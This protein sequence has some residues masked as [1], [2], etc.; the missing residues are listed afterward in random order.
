MTLHMM[1][2]GGGRKMVIE[3]WRVEL[4]KLKNKVKFLEDKV[5][6]LEQEN[7]DLKKKIQMSEE[8]NKND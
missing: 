6:I 7:A 8:E 3:G 5:S 1:I 2:A 4:E